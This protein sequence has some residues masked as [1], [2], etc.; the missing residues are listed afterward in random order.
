M[1][2]FL[3]SSNQQMAERLRTTLRKE[4]INLTFARSLVQAKRLLRL[5]PDIFM[6]DYYVGSQKGS[7]IVQELQKNSLLQNVE[8]WLTGHNLS[9]EQ[10]NKTLRMIK[11][12]KYWSQPIS[13][14][15]ILDDLSQRNQEEECALSPSSVRMIGQVWFSRTSAML[16]GS[17][18]RLIFS[19][20]AIIREDPK[21]CLMDAMQEEHLA[22]ASIQNLSGGSWEETGKRLILG[23]QEGYTDFWLQE[24]IKNAFRLQQP[25]GLEEVLL[26]KSLLSFLGARTSIEEGGLSRR[27][28]QE[29]Y[30]LWLLGAVAIEKA[31]AKNSVLDFDQSAINQ[32]QTY[33]WVIAEYERLK[34]ADS[35]IILGVNSKMDSKLILATT[36]RMRGRYQDILAQSKIS[37]DVRI[38]A[39]NMLKLIEKASQ[40]LSTMDGDESLPEYQR[41]FN[42]AKR[43]LE[44][45][46]WTQ[47]YK[48]LAKAHQMRIEDVDILAHLG[49]ALYKADESKK[50]E[51]LENMQ[52]ALHLDPQNIDC[53]V[54]LGT[55][56]CDQKDYESAL[57]F[58]QKVS[59]L[60]PDPKI[61]AL[62]EHAEAEVKII[63]RNKEG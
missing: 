24:N 23:C 51:A 27:G 58:L 4:D 60:T 21:K 42:Y 53:L 16:T 28:K 54:F 32:K 38:A 13:Y 31:I 36:R 10:Q 12:S 45:E 11:G 40:S 25:V 52:L 44:K 18:T 63:E 20:G 47:A 2:V 22:F 59:T 15:D 37:E 19:Q 26:S 62:R 61:Q 35:E 1:D 46:D 9:K 33:S 39:K 41:I 6:I 57:P 49:W 34:T 30:G 56:F 8:I 43:M 55:F 3:L 14:F 48:A 17:T 5:P 29:L 50:D 7:D